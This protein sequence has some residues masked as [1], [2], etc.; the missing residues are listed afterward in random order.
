MIRRILDRIDPVMQDIRYAARGLRRAPAFTVA[1]VLTLALGIGAN[2]TIFGILDRLMFKPYPRLMD[3]GSV[4]RVYLQSSYRGTRSTGGVSEYTRYLDLRNNTS[5]FEESA[6]MTSNTLAVGVGE[7]ARERPVGIVSASFF[8]FFDAPPALGRYFTPEEDSTPRGA[9]VAVL[10]Y[11]FWQ[12]EYGGRDVRGEVIQVRNIPCVIIGVAPRGFVGTWEGNPPAL[13]IPITTFAGSSY[14]QQ[15]ATSYYTRYNWGWMEMM[16]RRKP[17]VSVDAAS[18]DLTQAYVRS[19]NAM[20][21]QEPRVESVALAQPVA[22]AGPLKTA[23]GPDPGIEARTV[24][25]VGAIALIVLLIACSNVAN[26]FL[27]RALRRRRETAVR[28]ALGVS[29]RQLIRQW[30]TESLM[31]SLIGCAVGVLIAQWGGA[32]LRA[33]FV[34]TGAAIPVASDWRTL[35]VSAALAV[36][37]GV[38]AAIAPSLTVGRA[39]IAGEL[40]AGAREGTYRHSRLRTML[41]VTQIT[42]SVVLLVGAGV[43]VRSFENVRALRLGYDV[44]PALLVVR[45]MRGMSVPDSQLIQIS[46]QLLERAK[47]LPNVEYATLASSIPFYSTSSTNLRVPGIDS[48]ARLGRFTYQT[49]TADYFAAMDTRILRGRPFT[50]HDRAG[51]EP[52]IVVSESMGKVLWPAQDPLDKCVFVGGG[53]DAPCRRVIGIAEDAAQNQLQGEDRFRYY[54]PLDQYQPQ[55]GSYLIVRVKGDVNVGGEA[56]RKALQPVMPGQSYVT[57]RPMNTLIANQQRAWRFG[58]TMFFAFG[59]LALAVA[60]VGLYGVIGYNVAQRM[61]ELGV[62]IALGAQTRD[63]IRLVMSQG[64]AVAAVGVLTGIAVAFAVGGQVQPLL[65][66]QSARD[67][68]VFAVVGATLLAAATLACLLPA[69][70][71]ARAD[72][73][74][75][76][77]S[78]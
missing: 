74:R 49:A 16:V 20:K 35:G 4:H 72:P 12:N 32:S 39:G 25:W 45:N 23:A 46:A 29:R 78:E 10:G 3:Q 26:L 53:P 64:L 22:I 77:R 21:Q 67:P 9:E 48:V 40:K 56:I 13:Y 63:V 27:A 14:S 33:L 47:G 38:L 66:R 58:A 75:T 52:V 62:R 5:S 24:R 51:T 65:F 31:L 11:S 44:D 6:G 61:H 55:R 60:T 50:E 59:I 18:A 37:V 42:L 54:M 41:L 73:N 34:G 57:T 17:G 36:A 28:I 69:R 1:V 7:A 76:L 15:D 8:H 19:W 43:F 70:R 68:V 71:A 2:T 30:F